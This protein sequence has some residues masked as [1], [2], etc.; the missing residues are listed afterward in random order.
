MRIGY[1]NLIN[2]ASADNNRMMWIP[3][4]DSRIMQIML[5]TASASTFLPLTKMVI[6]NFQGLATPAECY[7]KMA[8]SVMLSI[9]IH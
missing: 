8:F 9:L 1:N 3:K 6:P 4:S 5:I 2:C 7:R